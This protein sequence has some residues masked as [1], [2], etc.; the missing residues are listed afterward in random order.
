MVII[1]ISAYFQ[2]LS[3]DREDMTKTKIK[4]LEM[5][6]TMSKRKTTLE[7]INGTLSIVEENIIKLKTY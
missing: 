6:I 7:R 1:T 5:K 2:K 3:R 4:L